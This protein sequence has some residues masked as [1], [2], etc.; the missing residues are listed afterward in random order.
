MFRKFKLAKFKISL[1][2]FQNRYE[3][4]S[5]KMKK[6]RFEDGFN[7]KISLDKA[8]EI[9]KCSKYDSFVS[10]KRSYRKLHTD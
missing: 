1:V 6:K 7:G 9:L 10:I 4:D 2:N 5:I 8:Y 3:N